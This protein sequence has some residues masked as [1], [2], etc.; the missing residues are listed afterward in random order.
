MKIKFAISAL[1]LS[2]LLIACGEKDSKSTNL[3]ELQSGKQSK[4]QEI[5]VSVSYKDSIKNISNQLDQL[6]HIQKLKKHEIALLNRKKDSVSNLLNQVKESTEQVNAKKIAPGIEG[7]NKKLSELKGQRENASE[8]LVLQEQEIVLAEK[9]IGLLKEEKTVY[10]SQHKALWSKGAAPEDFKEVDSLLAGING[11]INKQTLKIKTLKSTSADIKEQM[12]S[13]DDQRSS[14]SSKIRNNYTAKQIFDE[15][16]LE[17]QGRLVE[18]LKI[19]DSSLKL[20]EFKSDSLQNKIQLYSGN[21]TSFE[22]IEI[23]NAEFKALSQ[24][25][26]NEAK[27]QLEKEKIDKENSKKDKKKKTAFIVVGII[28]AILILFYFIG[29]MR[30][31]KMKNQS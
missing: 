3:D 17:E 22:T 30:K 2:L 25:E 16:A 13:I 4:S 19:I 7:V 5:V 10:D 8:Q 12:T 1:F 20:N 11:E 29:K 23:N 14:L 27:A 28:G 31:S 18:Q 24:K 26:R 9:K 15:Y 21:K 6:M